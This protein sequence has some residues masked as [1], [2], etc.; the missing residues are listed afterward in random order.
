[1][2]IFLMFTHALLRNCY[3]WSLW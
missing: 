2:P 3:L 1:M